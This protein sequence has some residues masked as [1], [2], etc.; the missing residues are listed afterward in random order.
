VDTVIVFH[1]MVEYGEDKE[2]ADISVS[3]IS[4]HP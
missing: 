3:K 1:I 2:K 4:H